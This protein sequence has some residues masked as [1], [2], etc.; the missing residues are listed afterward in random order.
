MSYTDQLVD[1]LVALTSISPETVSPVV[2]V[3]LVKVDETP[4]GV[5]YEGKGSGRIKMARLTLN[6]DGPGWL[7]PV[8]FNLD[9]AETEKDIDRTRY[10]AETNMSI[11]PNMGDEG[12]I[13]HSHLYWGYK[14]SFGFTYK[15]K[16]IFQCVL[17]RD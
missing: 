2:G 14:L 6:K 11:N 17:G 13:V 3:R 12:V 1:S 7:L 9:Q 16:R 4:Y 8:Y 10:G 5:F 15:T